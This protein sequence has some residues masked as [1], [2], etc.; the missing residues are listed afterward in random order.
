MNTYRDEAQLQRK[1]KMY[2]YQKTL[3]LSALQATKSKKQTD[4]PRDKNDMDLRVSRF[5]TIYHAPYTA[6]QNP[7]REKCRRVKAESFHQYKSYSV[8]SQISC[9]PHRRF[10]NALGNKKQ[11]PLHIMTKQEQEIIKSAK[12][13]NSIEYLSEVVRLMLIISR[14]WR[15][16]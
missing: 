16:S 7:K 6:C 14:L 15:L 4:P 5:Q 8:S 10:A 3:T 13:T 1:I 2:L 9:L 11:T 12:E